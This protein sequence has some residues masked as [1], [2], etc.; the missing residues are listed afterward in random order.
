M[1]KIIIIRTTDP[2]GSIFKSIVD[3]LQ[4]NNVEFIDAVSPAPSRLLIGNI[5]I[6][7]TYHQVLLS[8]KEV[9]LNHSEYAMLYCM[10]KAPGRVYTREQLY[11]AAWEN[12]VYPYGSNTVENT[13]F[14]LRQ[15]LEPDPKHPVYIKTVFRAGYKVEDPSRA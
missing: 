10:A 8:G 5:E 11:A 15:K 7:P 6:R 12:E 13:I 14:R 1:E 2:D 9:L 3:I 4:S